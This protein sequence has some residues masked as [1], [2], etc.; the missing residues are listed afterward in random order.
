MLLC[1]LTM[2]YADIFTGLDQ[3]IGMT[4]GVRVAGDYRIFL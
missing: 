3:A 1:Y 2:T 4:A